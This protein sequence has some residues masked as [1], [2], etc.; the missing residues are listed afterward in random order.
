M[1]SAGLANVHV[2]RID[3][4]ELAHVG[5]GRLW[6]HKMNTYGVAHEVAENRGLEGEGGS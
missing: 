5:I 2:I 6:R 1:S 4:D 3:G